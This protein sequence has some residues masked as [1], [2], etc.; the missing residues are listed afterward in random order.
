MSNPLHPHV[1]CVW[2]DIPIRLGMWIVSFKP[3]V[4]V[5]QTCGECL[6]HL[7]YFHH[8]R[9]SILTSWLPNSPIPLVISWSSWPL[10]PSII[11]CSQ[12]MTIGSGVSLKFTMMAYMVHSWTSLWFWRW[13]PFGFRPNHWLVARLV[14]YPL[15]SHILLFLNLCFLNSRDNFFW[16]FGVHKLYFLG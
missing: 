12:F 14:Q 6:N 2:G 8:T 7:H 5:C 11:Q 3:A 1:T 16:F 10:I 4:E 9:I 13:S 15:V